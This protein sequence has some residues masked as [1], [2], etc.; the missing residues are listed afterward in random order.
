M[1]VYARVNPKHSSLNQS[2]TLY[3]YLSPY[4]HSH[5]NTHSR[6]HTHT[7]VHTHKQ[8]HTNRYTYTHPPTDTHTPPHIHTPT[9]PHTHTNTPHHTQRESDFTYIQIRSQMFTLCSLYMPVRLSLCKACRTFTYCFVLSNLF[10]FNSH[11]FFFL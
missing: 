10:V 4:T 8:T 6:T 5:T 1:Y 11:F 3:L 2:L 7:H 9:D